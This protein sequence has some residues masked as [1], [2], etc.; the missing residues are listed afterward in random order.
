MKRKGERK[1]EEDLEE[2]EKGEEEN[3]KG[4]VK[5]IITWEEKKIR[6][7]KEKIVRELLK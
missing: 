7:Q 5:E 3:R 2:E 6:K 1:E 4:K